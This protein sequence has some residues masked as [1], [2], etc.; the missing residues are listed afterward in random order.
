MSSA[1]VREEKSALRSP[2]E[3]PQAPTMRAVAAELAVMIAAS[4]GQ[5]SGPEPPVPRSS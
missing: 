2:S 4:P 3:R 5:L 1:L